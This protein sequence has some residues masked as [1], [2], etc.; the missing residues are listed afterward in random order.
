M[1]KKRNII[2]GLI[3]FVLGGLSI[4]CCIEEKIVAKNSFPTL[5]A[6]LLGLSIIL[7]IL[8]ISKILYN[9]VE[10]NSNKELKIYNTINN[11]ASFITIFLLIVLIISIVVLKQY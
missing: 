5:F 3:Y 2:L 10:I 8:S 1:A 4:W 6:F 11:I 7:I 9:G